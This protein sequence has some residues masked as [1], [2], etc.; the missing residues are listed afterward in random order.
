MKKSEIIDLT[1]KIFGIHIIVLVILQLKDIHYLK[2]MFSYQDS[3]SA[4]ILS[5]VLF[6]GG[7]LIVFFV[8]YILIFKST[9]FVGKIIK[10]DTDIQITNNI[11]YSKVL[12]LALIIFGLFILIIRFPD[13]ISAISRFVGFLFGNMRQGYKY[14]IY[15]IA[16]IIHYIIG[17][18]LITNSKNI[19]NWIIKVNERNTIEN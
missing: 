9:F 19:S 3:Y 14:L 4:D 6:F 17:Y 16:S 12:D 10:D 8:G 13:F 15:D 5:L 7:G 11:N 1:L 18:L 2:T